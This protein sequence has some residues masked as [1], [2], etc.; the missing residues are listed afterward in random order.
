MFSIPKIGFHASVLSLTQS[1]PPA[2]ANF[3]P[4]TEFKPSRFLREIT[5]TGSLATE[6]YRRVRHREHC[7]VPYSDKS[8][9][10]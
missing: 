10:L 4:A 3:D 6:T 2:P 8:R 5:S 1:N 7:R 9:L